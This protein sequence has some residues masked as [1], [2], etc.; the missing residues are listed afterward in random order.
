MLFFVRIAVVLV[1]LYSS[2]QRLRQKVMSDLV[3]VA[4]ATVLS[5][6][7]FWVGPFC[8]LRDVVPYR[9]VNRVPGSTYQNLVALPQW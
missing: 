1:S 5:F 4:I 6:M 2:A 3:P 9:G 7:M 8:V